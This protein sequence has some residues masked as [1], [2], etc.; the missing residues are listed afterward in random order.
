MTESVTIPRS[1]IKERQKS[2]QSLMPPGLLESLPEREA[3][4]LL[5]FLTTEP[6]KPGSQ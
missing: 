2:A 4:E 3:L 5:K 1:E 6:T